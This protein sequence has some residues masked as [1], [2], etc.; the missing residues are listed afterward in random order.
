MTVVFS[1]DNWGNMRKLPDRSAPPRAG[2]YG[3]YYHYDYVGGGR[4]Y[5]WVDTNL[6]PNIWEQLNLAYTYGVDRLWVVNVG[7]LKNEELPTQFFLD[8]AWNPAKWPL[9]KLP[10]WERR[11]AAQ[12]FGV[13]HDDEIADVL[14][15]YGDLQSR[16][17][18]ELLNRLISL[19]PSKDLAT[20]STA[21][22][23]TTT[24]RAP[25]A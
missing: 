10:E 19:D 20:D 21:V 13:S 22:V 4:N 3:L 9:E 24:R 16:R 6:L 14:H 25:S 17:K 8:Y 2:G 5:K 18:P 15:D 12:N 7:D 1:D 11:F 23:T